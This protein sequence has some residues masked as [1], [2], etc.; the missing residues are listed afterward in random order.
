MRAFIT[1][2]TGFVGAHIARQLLEAGHEV[3]LL[4][5]PNSRTDLIAD[6]PAEHI[7]GDLMDS[8]ALQKGMAGCDWVFHTAAVADYWRAER[9]KMYLVNVQGARAVFEAAKQ[10]NVKRVLFTSSAAAVGLRAD[11]LPANEEVAFNLPPQRFP[12]GHSKAL[13]ELEAKQA[14][15]A[16]LDVVT[17]NPSIIFGPGDLNLISGS[18]IVEFAR[19]TIPPTYPVGRVTAI[20]VRDVARAHILAAEQG[21][22]GQRYLLGATDIDYRTLMTMVAALVGA[23]PPALP[24]VPALV[25]GLSAAINGLRRLG[26]PLP[27]DGNQ[28]WLSARNVCHDSSKAR[29]Q[30][31][32]PQFSLQQS[33]ADTYTWYKTHGLI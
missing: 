28:V 11:G 9:T 23:N 15:A 32:E 31:A 25:P 7:M 24:L 22:S 10:A 27:I 5:R 14:V 1:G 4:R 8:A 3:R 20:D 19:G 13:A 2:A 21:Q 26:L 12:Y 29:H 33:L 16:G 18:M 30:L 17:L 6:L